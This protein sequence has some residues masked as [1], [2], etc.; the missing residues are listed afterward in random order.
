[1]ICVIVNL[2]GADQTALLDAPSLQPIT[3]KPVKELLSGVSL[4]RISAGKMVLKPWESRVY[5]Y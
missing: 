4:P 2:T 1:M 3:I 5:F